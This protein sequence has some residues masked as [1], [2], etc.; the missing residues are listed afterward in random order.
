[1]S[2]PERDEQLT[3][4][5]TDLVRI[6]TENPPGNE[7]PCAEYVAAWFREHDIDVEVIREPYED[8]PQVVARVGSGEPTLVL[9]G[10]M[11]VVPAGD[12]T[13]WGHDPYGAALVDGRL[14]GRGS[15]D[16]KIGLALAMLTAARMR[17][18]LESG[19]LTGTLLVHAAIGEETAEPGTRTL[20][21]RG[22][23]G[24][25]G[26]VLEPTGFRTATSQKGA[27]WYE[28]TV[29]G[30]PS[31]ASRPDQGS[32]AILDAVPVLA[33]LDEY[34]AEVRTQTHDLC[35]R[36]YATVTELEAGTGSNVVPAGATI[37][38]DRRFLPGESVREL[39]DEIDTRLTAVESAFGLETDWE[40]VRT[41]DSSSIPADSHFADRLRHHSREIADADPAP[42]GTKAASDVRNLINDAGMEAVV[43][44]PGSN[45]QA[46]TR[47][48]FIDIDDAVPGLTILGAVIRDVF[49][50]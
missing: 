28:I 22:Y 44:G 16:M 11:D 38:L 6:E 33:A 2:T 39:D 32:N 18:P 20:L 12:R 26:I 15:T 14:Y 42:L 47:D 30:E 10:H 19:A 17:N 35:G 40:R 48:E 21:E 8:R 49:A 9:N 37:T 36:S 46:H 24:E 41:Y 1:M 45:E 43:W 7:K 23:D 34:D 29:T 3:E 50:E 4:L 27:A 25:F 13:E 31:H 5:V